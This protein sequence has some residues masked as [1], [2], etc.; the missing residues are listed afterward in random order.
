MATKYLVK[1]ATA[2]DAAAWG[3]SAMA[4]TDDFIIEHS[5]GT[6][7]GAALD[8]SGIVGGFESMLISTNASGTIG[9]GSAGPFI[10]D[11]DNSADAYLSNRGSVTLYYNAGGDGTNCK[12]FDCGGKSVNY[13]LGG[14][15]EV[16]TMDGGYFEANSSTALTTGFYQSAGISKIEYKSDQIVLFDMS[17]GQSTL[18]RMPTTANISGGRIELDIDDAETMTSTALN[19]SGNATVELKAGAIPTIVV[20]GG[21]LDLSKARRPIDLSGSSITVSG[22]RIVESPIV[23]LPT[24]TYVGAL[25]RNIGGPTPI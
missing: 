16:T 8:Q 6:I 25:K 14:T 2:F 23:T 15:I 3:G 12:N 22:G 18:K 21:V 4:A 20:K 19:V 17:G 5:F 1:G 10:A 24:I 13:I 9:G 11:F 7:T